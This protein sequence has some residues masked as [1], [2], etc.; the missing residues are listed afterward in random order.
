MIFTHNNVEDIRKYYR[1]TYVKFSDL[2]ET[3][4]FIE[5][6]KQKEIDGEVVPCVIGKTSSGDL[7]TL[8]LWADQPYEVEYVLPKKGFFVHKGNLYQLRRI[9]ARQ[10]SRGVCPDNTSIVCFD[11]YGVFNGADV[12]AELLQA[13][14]NKPDIKYPSMADIKE[15]Q[16]TYACLLLSRRI[17]L[18]PYSG[19]VLVDGMV[20]GGVST[21]GVKVRSLFYP[22]LSS[23][24]KGSDIPVEV[25]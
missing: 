17:V 1:N 3:I 9:P 18:L 12:T 4:C 25:L 10:Y 11:K 7:F 15:A 6:V 23:L 8:P 2:G 13:Y 21:E 22:E 19:K 14:V 20:V 5:E 24:L 16:Q